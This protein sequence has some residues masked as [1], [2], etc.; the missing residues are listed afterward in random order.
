M[1][2]YYDWDE[3]EADREYEAWFKAKIL[4]RYVGEAKGLEE[5]YKGMPVRANCHRK[6]HAGEESE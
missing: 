4:G 3:D 5:M 6:I 1:G 2:V